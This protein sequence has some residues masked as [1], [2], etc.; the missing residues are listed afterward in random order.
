MWCDPDFPYVIESLMPPPWPV[1]PR[2]I[3]CPHT[4][5]GKITWSLMPNDRLEVL[6]TAQH[7]QALPEVYCVLLSCPPSS[8]ISAVDLQVWAK[9]ASQKYNKPILFASKK[10]PFPCGERCYCQ[11]HLPTQHL[12]QAEHLE[13]LRHR[14]ES[15][16]AAIDYAFPSLSLRDRQILRRWA[17]QEDPVKKGT[18]I[19][20][21]VLATEN[22]LSTRQISRIL[23]LA[24]TVNPDVFKKIKYTRE[25]RY[26]KTG[27]YEVK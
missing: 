24:E 5:E 9:E 20:Q 7:A 1:P 12:E 22:A 18:P 23:D 3:A 11:S 8:T 13:H 16:D 17:T 14:S 26:R 4:P 2:A 27:A 19:R 10:G 25:Y 21:S 15:F 6:R